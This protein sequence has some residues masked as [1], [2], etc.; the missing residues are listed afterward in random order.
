MVFTLDNSSLLSNQDTIP[1]NFWYRRRLNLKFLIQRSEI[2]PVKLIG[3]PL[4]L[5][6]EMHM[7]LSKD[8]SFYSIDEYCL[9]GLIM[10][11]PSGLEK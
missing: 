7:R 6:V 8:I 4:K 3:A 2:L 5:N 11:M 10:T 1:I 9:Q